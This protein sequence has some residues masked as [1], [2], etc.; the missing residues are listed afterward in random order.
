M[1]IDKLKNSYDNYYEYKSYVA[2]E[3]RSRKWYTL[4]RE[5]KV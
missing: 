2:V 5:T 1:K 4:E 3:K